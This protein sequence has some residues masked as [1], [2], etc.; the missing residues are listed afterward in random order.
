ML[1]VKVIIALIIGAI[2]GWKFHN[3]EE[4]CGME[5]WRALL[6]A[7]LTCLVAAIIIFLPI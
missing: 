6:W 4:E 1:T 3:Y 5:M 2:S 7:G